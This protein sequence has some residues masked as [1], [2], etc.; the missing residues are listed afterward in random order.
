MLGKH[1]EHEGVLLGKGIR[2]CAGEHMLHI[3]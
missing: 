1:I 3:D 2:V